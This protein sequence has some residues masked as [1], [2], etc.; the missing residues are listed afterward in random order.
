MQTAKQGVGRDGMP[1]GRMAINQPTEKLKANKE[2]TDC[3]G[4]GE[5]VSYTEEGEPV[6]VLCMCRY[7]PPRRKNYWGPLQQPI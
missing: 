1:L 5:Y 2:C 6:P 4:I 7:E 3:R